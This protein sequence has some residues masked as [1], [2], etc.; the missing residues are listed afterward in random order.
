MDNLQL[1]QGGSIALASGALANGTNPGTI[2]T[3]AVIPYTIDGQFL[4]KAIT[5]NIAIAFTGPSVFSDSGNGSFT[6]KTGG[7]VRLYGLFL[8]SSGN[9]S[10]AP[11]RITNVADL[12]AGLDSLQFPA[13][14]RGKACF[15]VLRIAVTAGTTF[16]P[17]TTALNAAGVTASYLNLS[18][19]PG[20]PL[21]T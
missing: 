16:I 19:V 7:S 17:G 1:S 14:Q 15:G 4:S 11:G 13:P 20:E 5:N 6:G 8:D 2:Q 3:T 18:G 21:K 12:A 10:V 9:V